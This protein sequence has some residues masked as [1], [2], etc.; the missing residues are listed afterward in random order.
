MPRGPSLTAEIVC[1]FRAWEHLRGGADQILDDPLAE[2]FLRPLVRRWLAGPLAAPWRR[3]AT[4]SAAMDA[5]TAFVVAR[6]RTM[7]DVLADALA[8]GVGQTVLLGA[9]YDT[10]AWR[11][12][13]ERAGRPH[14]E[15]DFAPT[16]ERK[17]RVAARTGLDAAVGQVFVPVDFEREAFD[18]KLV[19]A[20]FRAGER[21]LFVWEGVTMY[22]QRETVADTLTRV[23][24][25][26]GPGTEIVADFWW[27]P[28]R[29]L[30]TRLSR[31]GLGFFHALGEPLTFSLAQ[32]E[33]PAFF[34]ALGWDV[35]GVAD[36]AELLARYGRDAPAFQPPLF[37]V[38]AKAR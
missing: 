6:H 1:F 5:M 35:V 2:R 10:R 28:E 34:D 20:G 11:F 15:L 24:A 17:R 22:L 23:R 8:A 12:E 7:D 13:V 27:E 29:S 38:H 18:E 14:Y 33:A 19:G 30:W 25:L 3:V 36:Q 4:L 26:G 21:A 31:A 9:G 32:A 37:V 16:Q